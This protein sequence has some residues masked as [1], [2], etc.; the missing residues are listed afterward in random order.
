[1]NVAVTQPL[2]AGIS[3]RPWA[4]AP[5]K[6]LM[7][8]MERRVTARAFEPGQLVSVETCRLILDAARLAPSGANAQPW[9][10]IAVTDEAVRQAVAACLLAAQARRAKDVP[11]RAERAAP[12]T[13]YRGA[14][15]APGCLVVATDFRLSWAYPG[16]MDG[17]E[18]DQRYHATAERILLQSVAC[19]VMAAHLAATALGHQTWWIS[20]LAQDELQADL[21]FLL[22]VP[23]D[24]TITD[25][26]LFGSAA[27]AAPRRWKKQVDEVASWNRFDLANFRSLNQIDAWVRDLRERVRRFG[28]LR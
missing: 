13:D 7:E 26:L 10:Y 20:T 14:A 25:I 3:G 6:A 9:Q 19:S 22:G 2:Q 28:V 16:L 4:P 8:V 21:R 17:T 18:L 15:S 5:Y 27:G 1:M 24:L 23:E 12:L 11:M